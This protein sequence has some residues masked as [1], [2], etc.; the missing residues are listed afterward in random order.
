[1][2]PAL[3]SHINAL[4]ESTPANEIAADA[5][6]YRVVRT[7]NVPEFRSAWD[8]CLSENKHFDDIIDEMILKEKK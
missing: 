6:R 4:I 8:R 7:F 1:M 2:N 5:L 3:Q